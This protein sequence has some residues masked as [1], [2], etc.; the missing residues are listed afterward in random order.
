[1]M[2]IS[3]FYYI[4]KSRIA[5][6]FAFTDCILSSDIFPIFFMRRRSSTA[7][8]WSIIISQSSFRLAI[9]FDWIQVDAIIGVVSDQTCTKSD[10]PSVTIKQMMSISSQTMLIYHFSV[11][12]TIFLCDRPLLNRDSSFFGDR[13]C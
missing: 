8:I 12:R 7:L 13:R 1:M 5:D 11:R 4:N 6:K 2:L 3:Y 10:K 9:P